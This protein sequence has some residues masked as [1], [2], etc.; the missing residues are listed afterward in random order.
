MAHLK[1]SFKAL[2]EL[3]ADYVMVQDKIT[4][5]NGPQENIE[6]R[7]ARQELMALTNLLQDPTDKKRAVVAIAT[8]MNDNSFVAPFLQAISQEDPALTLLKQQAT[9]MQQGYEQQIND[10]KN[11]IQLLKAQAIS[12]DA[13]NKDSL[14]K[15]ELDNQTKIVIEQMKQQ[16]LDG[17]Q[18]KEQVHDDIEQARKEQAEDNRAKLE[19]INKVTGGEL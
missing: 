19:A 16:G 18:A 3:L 2:C 15:A 8:T 4:I 11:Q 6:R 10:L 12:L 7:A 14:R 1:Y 5:E 9:Q 17:R 13:R